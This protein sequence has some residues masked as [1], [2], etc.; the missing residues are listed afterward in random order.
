MTLN[1]WT[2]C[3]SPTT[4]TPAPRE[5]APAA[6]LAEFHPE[7]KLPAD[8]TEQF[9]LD[10]NHP[11]HLESQISSPFA[12]PG[13]VDDETGSGDNPDHAHPPWTATSR[14]IE[15]SLRRLAM[16][17]PV[18]ALA[19][20]LLRSGRVR[21]PPTGAA[22]SR[23]ARMTEFRLLRHGG[24]YHAVARYGS[25]IWTPFTYAGL[26]PTKTG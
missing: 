24:F 14:G 16:L 21:R 8:S 13:P 6:G 15:T 19:P 9:A 26:H 3:T 18:Y 23:E 20:D 22:A 5:E 10:H 4:R 2:R 17:E 12:G 7:G 11:A 25:D 1:R